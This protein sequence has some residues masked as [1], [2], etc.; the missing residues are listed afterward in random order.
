[1]NLTLPNLKPP[2]PNGSP[3][4]AFY[5]KIDF[6]MPTAKN[7]F[8]ILNLHPKNLKYIFEKVPFLMP[9]N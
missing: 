5:K 2:I 6:Q 9:L 7:Q 3:I 1:M 8:Q 4:V